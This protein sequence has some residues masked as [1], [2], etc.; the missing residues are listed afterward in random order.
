MRIRFGELAQRGEPFVDGRRRGPRRG[1]QWLEALYLLRFGEVL[2]QT[3]RN[4][5]AAT[6]TCYDDVLYAE[7]EKCV[8]DD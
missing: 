1:L 3:D 8:G 7:L 6:V 5:A 4:A 2:V